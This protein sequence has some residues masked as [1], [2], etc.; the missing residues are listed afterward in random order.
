MGP[1]PHDAPPATITPDNPVGTDGF[2]FVEFAHPQPAELA[3][4]FTQMGY[5]PVARHKT[6]NIT[7]YRQGDINYVVNAEP[8]SFATRFVAAHGPCA[9]AMAW[10]VVDARHAF[11]HAVALGAEP[12][13][14]ARPARLQVPAIEGIGGSL[15]YF[16]DRYGAKGS[17][18]DAKSSTG[19]ARPI[20]GRAASASIISTTSPTTSI[21]ATWTPGS[22]SMRGSSTSA[23]IRFFNIEGKLTGLHSRAL[24]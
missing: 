11:E 22:A 4:L 3:R 8:G 18:Y 7:L 19:S 20:R 24:T 9:P 10:R 15:I 23:Q 17:P 6:K 5:R 12:Y 14:G 1:F 21:A 13:T 2:E 16:V